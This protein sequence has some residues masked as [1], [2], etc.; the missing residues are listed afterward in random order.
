MKFLMLTDE[1]YSKIESVIK[2]DLKTND[3]ILYNGDESDSDN[4]Y[5]IS[6]MAH[7]FLDKISRVQQEKKR[8][9]KC[10]PYGI[11]K[12]GTINL[13]KKV[14]VSDPCYSVST[15]CTHIFDNVKPGEYNVF[16]NYLEDNGD[17][18]WGDRVQSLLVAHN[19]VDV[20]ELF[21][22]NNCVANVGVDSGQMSIYNFEEYSKED[23]R[24]DKICN[25]TNYAGGIVANGAVSASGY[26]DGSY[27]VYI[28]TDDKTNETTGINIVFFNDKYDEE[29]EDE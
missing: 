28:T 15:W 29:S 9:K 27:N 24:Y 25:V 17:I 14:I 19:T 13:N 3:N 8:R 20:N 22:S 18:G 5:L 12:L 21:N 16:V 2:E 6:Y 10:P 11:S 1:V 4:P 7:E 26:G 23:E